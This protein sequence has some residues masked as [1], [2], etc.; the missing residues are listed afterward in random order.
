MGHFGVMSMRNF[1]VTSVRRFLVIKMEHIRV[2]S[3]GHFC[4]M[5]MKHFRVLTKKNS[6]NGEGLF[7]NHEHQIIWING[8]GTFLRSEDE[9]F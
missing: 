1:S 3:L 9:V 8:Y 4:I 7:Q 5:I 2:K 6:I